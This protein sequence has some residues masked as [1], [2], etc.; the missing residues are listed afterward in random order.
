MLSCYTYFPHVGSC[1]ETG[2]LLGAWITVPVAIVS[3][4]WYIISDCV[5]VSALMMNMQL[6]FYERNKCDKR[7]SFSFSRLF[8][9][10]KWSC[11]DSCLRKPRLPCDKWNLPK[12]KG[13]RDWLRCK[14]STRNKIIVIIAFVCTSNEPVSLPSTCRPSAC[15][16]C[17]AEG[18]DPQS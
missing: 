1:K 11:Y 16:S 3:L 13:D 15:Q 18:I 5:D 7:N 12:R 8:S 17:Q 6:H 10:N 4:C 2:W 14:N 9:F